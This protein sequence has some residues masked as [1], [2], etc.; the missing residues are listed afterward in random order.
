MKNSLI[1]AFNVLLLPYTL[2]AMEVGHGRQERQKLFVENTTQEPIL[3]RYRTNT[4]TE[5]ER[6]IYP[7]EAEWFLDPQEISY[8]SV[9]P[10]RL[11]IQ[12]LTV[13]KFRQNYAP[14]ISKVAAQGAGLGH[15]NV[16]DVKFTI[17]VPAGII[18]KE[19]ILAPYKT[20]I[21]PLDPITV[22]KTE[23]P[24]QF[25]NRLRAFKAAGGYSLPAHILGVP[26]NANAVSIDAAYNDLTA[27]WQERNEMASGS[28]PT[29]RVRN[30][31]AILD[32]AH[33]I[34]KEKN[35]QEK[36]RKLAELKS[37]F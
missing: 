1:F 27:I 26:E 7:K 6:V 4:P 5:L 21:Q 17:T 28:Y 23:K 35:P 3:V 16:D 22:I 34:L 14:D 31:L 9:E 37:K 10:Y 12:M 18:T 32:L 2:C 24:E 8:F 15:E 20:Q 11:N 13:G 19:A 36:A 33:D 30:I 25:Y 29:G